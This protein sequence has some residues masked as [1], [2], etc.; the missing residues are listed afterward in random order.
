M[1]QGVG[2]V[3]L[4]V[5]DHD[6]A[7]QFYVERVGFRVHTDI[8]NGAYRWVTVQHPEQPSLQLQLE[9]PGAPVLDDASA[10]A[11]RELLAKG[12]MPGLVLHVDDCRAQVERMRAAGVEI[13]QEPVDRFGNV[14]AGFRD[15][16][17]NGWKVIQQGR[18]R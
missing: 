9:V 2:I 7:V 14:D 11:A 8:R 15:P 3:S 12:G 1:G 13:T 17:G 16:S 10:A 6:E 5:R 4:Y 18:G